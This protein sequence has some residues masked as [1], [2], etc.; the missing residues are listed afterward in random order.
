MQAVFTK[1]NNKVEYADLGKRFIATSLDLLLLLII[2]GTIDYLTF[3]SNENAFFFKPERVLAFILGWLYFAGMETC[4]CKA[5]LGKY[6]IGLK[7]S[8]PS[9]DRLSFKAA[10]IRYFTKPVSLVYLMLCYIFSKSPDAN[11]PLHDKLAQSV[12]TR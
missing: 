5:T 1:T 10:T 2:I 6:L 7:V 3:S 11:T 8:T 9:G 4:A 12:V